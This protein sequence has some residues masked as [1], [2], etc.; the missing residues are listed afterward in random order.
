MAEYKELEKVLG[1]GE[2]RE[3]TRARSG[4]EVTIAIETLRHN[5]ARFGY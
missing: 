4:G 1:G 2:G 3:V 5:F